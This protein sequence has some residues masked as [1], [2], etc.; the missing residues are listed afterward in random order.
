MANS[1]PNSNN[2][3]FF[4]MFKS[5]KSL[6]GKHTVFGKVVEGFGTLRM[7]QARGS[8]SGKPTEIVR[9]ERAEIRELPA[10]VIAGP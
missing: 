4:V 9:I 5:V 3:Q 2:S 6:D 1:G 8:K 10:K 7:L